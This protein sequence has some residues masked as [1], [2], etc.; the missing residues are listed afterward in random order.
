[1]LRLFITFVI[2]F[3]I[4]SFVSE[5]VCRNCSSVI[6]FD[7]LLAINLVSAESR[8]PV[9]SFVNSTIPSGEPAR[10]ES[11]LNHSYNAR[12]SVAKKS[13]LEELKKNQ[14]TTIDTS[15]GHREKTWKPRISVE[16]RISTGIYSGEDVEWCEADADRGEWNWRYIYGKDKYN[17]FDPRIYNRLT[18]NFEM[19]PTSNLT[20][21]SEFVI[22]PWSFVGSTPEV[23]IENN[24]HDTA[25]VRLKYWSST[26]KTIPEVIRTKQGDVLW[27]PEIEVIDNKT[28]ETYVPGTWK[29]W[30]GQCGIFH[31]GSLPVKNKFRP[32][33]EFHI[34]YAS[35]T[36]GLHL[37]PLTDSSFALCSD[38][39]LG[40][41]NHHIWWEQSPWLNRWEPGTFYS[42]RGA[43]A[44]GRGYWNRELS[45]FTRDSNYERLTFLRGVSLEAQLL[46]TSL[47]MRIASPMGLWDDYDEINNIS[48]A[49]RLK[50]DKTDSWMIGCIYINRI[51]FDNHRTD[52]VNQVLGV[53]TKVKVS[54]NI[55]LITEVAVSQTKTD[56]LWEWNKSYRGYAFTAGVIID[57]PKIEMGTISLRLDFTR[58][59]RD[60]SSA[61]ACYR[62]TRSDP[63]WSRHISFSESEF[64]PG[65]EVFRLGDGV[66]IDRDVVGLTARATLFDN[67]L[68][69]LFNL[70]DVHRQSSGRHIE[71]VVRNES[72]YKLIPEKLAVKLLLLY[73]RLPKTQKGVEPLIGELYD[74]V[75][76]V[77]GKEYRNG[78]VEEGKDPSTLTF[79][80]GL[81]YMLSKKWSIEGI[82]ER[83]NDYSGFPQAVL[84]YLATSEEHVAI[85]D[86]IIFDEPIPTLSEDV[87]NKNIY[88]LPPYKY[89]N[90]I[91]GKM[92]YE[93]THSLKIMLTH[94]YNE[95]KFA[96]GMDDNINHSGLAIE[97]DKN[98]FSVGIS[99]TYSKLEDLYRE[100]DSINTHYG[101]HHNIYAKCEYDLGKQNMLII[102]YGVGW[103]HPSATS[104]YSAIPWALPALDTQHLL[105][106]TFDGKW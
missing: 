81:K 54:P 79:S 88:P 40:L 44:F 38:D 63:W 39:P 77:E 92:S 67:R 72:T 76:L 78:F 15:T 12:M 50:R 7:T 27:L 105:R 91:R 95:D 102:Q 29:N 18:V 55:Q 53:D 97:Y 90:V 11:R 52:V 75:P 99:Y 19:N 43:N 69:A 5:A 106:I 35:E 20:I 1:M 37:F 8:Y 89:Y 73:R 47:D 74:L 71:T 42:Q 57:K 64:Y 24:W 65:V 104:R 16:Y 93:P 41:S 33:R 85:I 86:G 34:G 70:R 26:G 84:A 58:M 28:A 32:V 83:T 68:D 96:C 10:L 13:T 2:V 36:F 60:F 98:S 45:F 80:G 17:T 59:E 21:D 6:E 62:N 30:Q 66:D 49:I 31:F 101:S 22:D 103:E 100:G 48:G 51:G 87:V 23:T 14:D 82:F 56:L 61:L 25:T 3:Y 9:K 4:V 46:G 94:T